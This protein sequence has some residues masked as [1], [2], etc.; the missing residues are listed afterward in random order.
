MRV[1]HQIQLKYPSIK[2]LA[3]IA[4]VPKFPILL[5]LNL[6]YTINTF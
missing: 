2:L 6:I 4:P 3:G 1:D 5:I